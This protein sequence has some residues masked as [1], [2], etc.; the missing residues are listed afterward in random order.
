[1]ANVLQFMKIQPILVFVL[2]LWAQSM[3]VYV[4]VNVCLCLY[5]VVH[6]CFYVCFCVFYEFVHLVLC[7][8][9]CSDG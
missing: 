8:F 1:M 3:C 9:M 4:R 5:V 2:D 7:V 6:M